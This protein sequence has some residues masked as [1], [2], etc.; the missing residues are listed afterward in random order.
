LAS[1]VTRK[2]GNGTE[3]SAAL[4]CRAAD[5]AFRSSIFQDAGNLGNLRAFSVACDKCATAFAVKYGYIY[6]RSRACWGDCFM[7]SRFLLLSTASYLAVATAGYAADMAP[8]LKAPPPPPVIASWTGFYIGVHG[9]VAGFNAKQ[10]TFTFEGS[11]G[12]CDPTDVI[13]RFSD[14]SGVFGGQAGYNWQIQN[15][16]LGVEGD[17]SWLNAKSTLL[18]DPGGE[19]ATATSKLDWVASAR[20]RLGWVVADG[21]G[22]IYVTGGAAWAGIKSGWLINDNCGLCP[23]N[24]QLNDTVT[25]VVAGGGVEAMLSRNWTIRAEALY[26]DFGHKSASAT[27]DNGNERATYTTRFNNT[28]L[29]G[30]FGLNFKW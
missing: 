18:I 29:V 24:V 19:N 7:K 16:V 26:Y 1:I 11:R 12:V 10:T 15:W 17:G 22:L 28:L 13:C 14:T 4:L 5:R 21:A 20:G 2:S 9:G 27:F 25:G 30:R 6:L 3:N 23:I 8:I